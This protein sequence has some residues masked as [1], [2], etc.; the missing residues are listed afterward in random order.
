MFQ[1]SCMIKTIDKIISVVFKDFVLFEYAMLAIF[2]P[3]C[4]T[5]YLWR[6][7]CKTTAHQKVE[8]ACEKP[9]LFSI[10]ERNACMQNKLIFLK[11]PSLLYLIKM[12]FEDA[13]GFVHCLFIKGS[14]CVFCMTRCKSRPWKQIKSLYGSPQAYQNCSSCQKHIRAFFMTILLMDTHLTLKT[15]LEYY[16]IVCLI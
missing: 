12:V 1:L 13:V 2:E 11:P 7:C 15:I 5:Y 3:C 4:I 9:G 10:H 6:S 16:D 8:I 14:Y